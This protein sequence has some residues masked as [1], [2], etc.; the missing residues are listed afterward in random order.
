MAFEELLDEFGDLGK[1]QILQLQLVLIL[2]SLM[3]VVCHL[4]LENFTAAIPSHRCWVHILDNGTVSDNDTG[5]LSPDVLLRISIPLDASLKPEKCHHFLLPQWHLL[6][7]NGTFPNMTDLDMEPCVGGWV[8]DRSSFSSTIVTEWDLVCDH[9]SQKRVVQSR[10][11]A[12]ML[13]WGLIYGHL[14]DG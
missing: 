4:L 7:L 5:T 6:H 1:F 9:Q 8:Y 2:P 13:V 10:F 11:M 3:I 14:S 12:G